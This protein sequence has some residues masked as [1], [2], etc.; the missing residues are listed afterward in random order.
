MSGKIIFRNVTCPHCHK[1][2]PTKYAYEPEVDEKELKDLW[3]KYKG[4]QPAIKELLGM[5]KKAEGRDI[6]NIDI[7]KIL[8]A[9]WKEQAGPWRFIKAFDNYKAKSYWTQGKGLNYF[10]AIFNSTK[11]EV[12]EY[13]YGTQPGVPITGGDTVGIGKEH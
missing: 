11:I 1:T 2:F 12:G 4:L 8:H 6:S 7:Q 9:I 10:L 13:G 5:I 3:N